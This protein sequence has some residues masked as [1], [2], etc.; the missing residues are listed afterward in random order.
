MTA[1]RLDVDLVAEAA[2]PDFLFEG[3]DQ[4]A[5][6][7]AMTPRARANRDARLR[8]LARSQDGGA[9]LFEFSR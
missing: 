1:G 6:A 8:R 9:K 5:R 4:L 3:A 7:E 2:F